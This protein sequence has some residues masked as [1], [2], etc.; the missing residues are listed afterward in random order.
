MHSVPFL[1]AAGAAPPFFAEIAA[2]LVASA[3]VAYVCSRLGVTPIVS[4]L[5]TGALIGPQALGLVRDPAIIEGAAEVGVVLLLFTIGIEL[6]LEE[7]ARI[8]RLI[9]LGGALQVGLSLLVVAGLLALFGVDGR[10]AI[11]TGC[12]LALSSTAIVMKLLASRGETA[13]VGGRAILGILIFQDLAV[14]AMVLVVPMLGGSGGSSVGVLWALAKA[15][16]I[17]AVVLLVARRVMP[18][19]LEAV[20]RTCSQE[21]FVL[22]V[23]AI[24]FGTAYLT[25][26][27]GVSLSLGAFLAGLLVSES[28]FKEMAFGEIQPLQILFSATFFVSVGLLLDLKFL[29]ANLPLVLGLA[30]VV[31]LIKALSAALSVRLLGIGLGTAL[32]SGLMIAQVGE[33]SFVLERTGREMGLV[34]AGMASGG[35]TFI[36]LTVI[37]M[38]STPLL[39]RLGGA[40]ESRLS[41]RAASG[42]L[43]D[44]PPAEVEAAALYA[45]LTGHVIIAGYGKVGRL[46]A[47]ALEAQGLPYLILTL[48]P[49]GALEAEGQG[50]RVLRGNYAR[51]HELSLA[52]LDRARLLVVADDDLEMT[53]RVVRAARAMN[54]ELPLIVRTR[55]DH[56]IEALEGAGARHVVT[57]E[58]ESAIR[59]VEKVLR[60]LDVAEETLLGVQDSLRAHHREISVPRPERAKRGAAASSIRMEPVR[61][62]ERE[63]ASPRCSHVDQTREVLPSAPGCEECLE[64]GDSWTHLRLCMTCGHVGCCDSSK[65]R[66]ATKHFQSTGHPI[67]KSI[68]PGDDWAWC[69]EDA[70]ML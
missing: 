65:N 40:L 41:R 69:Y 33:F 25:S 44:A 28:R 4:F 60:D 55:F 34:P 9:F 38:M 66:H 18:K 13:T 29:V 2:L 21:I 7:L 61:L 64:L 16:A 52:G 42:R 17:L 32:F 36:A 6:S 48:S 63:Q 26:L 50:L 39:A 5:V 45:D 31:V 46:L 35:Q 70:L 53:H 54:P 47:R 19:V 22:T 15:V 24:C 51:R 37:L 43:A 23:M 1:L 49:E 8:Q 59:L 14:V 58:Q 57:E 3:V 67:I 68:E 56:E 30:L 27:A 12:L 62:N 11:F 20:A 10:T